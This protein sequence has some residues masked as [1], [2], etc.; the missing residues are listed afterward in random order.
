[1]SVQL[2]F[3]AACPRLKIGANFVLMTGLVTEKE[4]FDMSNIAAVNLAGNFVPDNIQN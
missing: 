4:R 3:F 2:P 1:M